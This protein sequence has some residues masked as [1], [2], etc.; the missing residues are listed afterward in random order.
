MA[1]LVHTD[2]ETLLKKII[3]FIYVNIMYVY[4]TEFT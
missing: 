3:N 1:H 4:V 2:D